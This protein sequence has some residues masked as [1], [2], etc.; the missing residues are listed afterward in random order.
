MKQPASAVRRFQWLLLF[1]MLA[2]PLFWGKNPDSFYPWG[3]LG[4]GCGIVGLLVT[5]WLAP[6]KWTNLPHCLLLAGLILNFAVMA[7]NRGFM[8][9]ID[10]WLQRSHGCWRIAVPSDHL[11]FL[12]DRIRLVGQNTIMWWLGAML[13]DSLFTIRLANFL[14]AGSLVASVGDFL[15]FGSIVLSVLWP[16]GARKTRAPG[17]V[18]RPF[19][20][21]ITLVALVLGFLA[22]RALATYPG[23]ATDPEFLMSLIVPVVCFSIAGC[24]FAKSRALRQRARRL[25]ILDRP[26]TFLGKNPMKTL[27]RLRE[28]SDCEGRLKPK[29][30][31]FCGKERTVIS[32]G[33]DSVCPF[34][35]VE[36]QHEQREKLRHRYYDQICLEQARVLGAVLRHLDVLAFTLTLTTTA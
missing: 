23:Q 30:C 27:A 21:F 22:C 9:V 15:I 20:A 28:I 4:F 33:S 5:L 17:E 29:R 11:L 18:L 34:C 24:C 19:F 31:S 7:A 12:C 1:G 32:K 6:L 16:V 8:P 25:E 3:V 10:P 13:P 36:M 14:M 2:S 35:L 26:S